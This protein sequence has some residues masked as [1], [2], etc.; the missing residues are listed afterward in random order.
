LDI[1]HDLTSPVEKQFKALHKGRRKNIRRAERLNLVFREVKNRAEFTKAYELVKSTYQKVRLPMPDKD[2]FSIAYDKL[3][4]KDIFKTFV[5]VFNNQI[6]ATRMVLCF[7]H[8]IY[9]WYAGAS[10]KHLDKYPNDYLPW[11][12]MQWGKNN[13]YKTFDFGGAGKPGEEYGVRD[14][15]LKFGGELVN[16]GRFEKVHQP[17]MLQTGKVGFALWK[18]LKL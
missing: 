7:N 14:F 8:S 17:L 15:K 5:A 18:K 11:K 9:D 16:W 2:Y 6:I 13:G 12:I 3:A 10:E 4:Q 1:I